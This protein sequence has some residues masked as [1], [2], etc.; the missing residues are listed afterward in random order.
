MRPRFVGRLGLADAVTVGN[1]VLGFLAIA[2]ASVDAHLAARLVLL[3][4]IADGLDG[5][6]ARNVGSTPVGEHL[7][8]LSDVASFGVA[9]ALIV[10]ASAIDAWGLSISEPSLLL[11]LVLGVSALYVSMVVVRLGLYTV[12]DAGTDYTEG[13]PSTLAGTL[14]A[15]L[16][17]ARVGDVALLL[18]TTVLLAYLMVTTISYPDLL[19]RD[20]FLMGVVQALAILFPHAFGR[21]FPYAVLTLSV[22]YMVLSPRFYWREDQPIEPRGNATE[23]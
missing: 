2:V 22:A 18:G 13:A 4:A 12:Y 15:A 14:L 6:V 23:S 19:A 1:A 9:P 11:G 7:D 17:L 8:S 16:V 5:V 21:T 20:A 10:A 3:A